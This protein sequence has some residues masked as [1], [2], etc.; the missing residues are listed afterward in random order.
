LYELNS[1]VRRKPAASER[2]AANAPPP[3]RNGD[4]GNLALSLLGLPAIPG[5]TINASQDLVVEATASASAATP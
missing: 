1:T 4:A 3:I 2:F 5:S